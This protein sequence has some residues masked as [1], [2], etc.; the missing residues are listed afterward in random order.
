MKIEYHVNPLAS[1]WCL[2]VLVFIA[3]M[4]GMNAAPGQSADEEELCTQD[5][6]SAPTETS[7]R[8][9]VTGVSRWPANP[10]CIWEASGVRADGN[11]YTWR[12]LLLGDGLDTG[13]SPP[14]PPNVN[15][16]VIMGYQ[17]R[18][19]SQLL[20]WKFMGVDCFRPYPSEPFNLVV[21]SDPARR[22]PAEGDNARW[23]DNVIGNT[24]GFPRLSFEGSVRLDAA[25]NLTVDAT[26]TGGPAPEAAVNDLIARVDTSG[27]PSRQKRPL[28]ATLQ[29]AR[30]SV[31]DDECETAMN[32][33]HAFQNKV[34]AQLDGSA[35]TLAQSLI[36]G[37]QAVIDSGCGD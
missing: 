14:S 10:I 23:G 7:V 31:A 21:I 25:G 26:F 22:T 1:G 11:T 6:L 13:G 33:L 16:A 4:C 27:L 24:E 9:R 3:L 35:A 8:V 37:A 29:A 32:Q 17:V 28:L 18:S 34:R 2:A 20:G 5:V 19:G 30:A 12:A 36:A 15:V